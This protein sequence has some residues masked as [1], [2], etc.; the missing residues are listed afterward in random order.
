MERQQSNEIAFEMVAEIVHRHQEM[1][2]A[3]GLIKVAA[4]S[5]L[6]DASMPAPYEPSCAKRSLRVFFDSRV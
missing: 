5:L 1:I 6:L 3:S 4:M 2:S